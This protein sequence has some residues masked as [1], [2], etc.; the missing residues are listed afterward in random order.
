[1]FF[2]SFWV[3]KAIVGLVRAL[4]LR[5]LARGLQTAK[6]DGFKDLNVQLGRLGR[7][8]WQ[9]HAAEGVGEALD[10]HADRAVTLVRVLGLR[11]RVVVD[12]D[13][14]IQVLRHLLQI[15]K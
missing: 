5:Q 7:L 1:M 8:V 4:D 10:A 2:A 14:A 11:D 12:V 6:V 15:E 9:L 13:H 3:D